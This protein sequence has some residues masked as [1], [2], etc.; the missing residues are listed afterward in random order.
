[1]ERII[2]R[3]AQYL[4]NAINGTEEEYERINYMLEAYFYNILKLVGLILIFLI[5]GYLT[6]GL[7]GILIV[8]ITKFYYGGYHED[9]HLKC[10]IASLCVIGVAVYL[11]I[12]NRLGYTSLFAINIISLYVIYQRVPV[13]DMDADIVPPAEVIRK[14]RK[15]S[16]LIT[17]LIMISFIIFYW[18]AFYINIGTW[19]LLLQ[20][21]TL[22]VKRK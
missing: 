5:T 4:A 2:S 20:A 1:M 7:V 6:Q 14:Y 18:C 11:G 12:F 16:L 8:L 9:T 17:L 3:A 21:L 10:F 15:I 19:A 22:F 13:I